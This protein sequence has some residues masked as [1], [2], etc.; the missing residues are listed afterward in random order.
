[1]PEGLSPQGVALGSVMVPLQGRR[2]RSSDWHLPG[3]RRDSI[4]TVT[5]SSQLYRLTTNSVEFR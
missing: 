1:M 4:K 3:E 5:V 2:K